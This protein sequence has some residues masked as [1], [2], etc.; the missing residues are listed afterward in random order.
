M[1]EQRLSVPKTFPA[2]TLCKSAEPRL[3][4]SMRM[5]GGII[6]INGCL[7][8][9]V[10]GKPAA[11]VLQP[12]ILDDGTRIEPGEFLRPLNEHHNSSTEADIVN[13]IREGRQRLELPDSQW[14]RIRRI[15]MNNIREHAVSENTFLDLARE[16]AENVSEYGDRYYIGGML[17]REYSIQEP[18]RDD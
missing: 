17:R 3:E 11:L 9:K 14:G 8:F 18:F 10:I 12:I 5:T 7:L 1:V 4:S 6:V 2:Q 13:A 15:N 16:H